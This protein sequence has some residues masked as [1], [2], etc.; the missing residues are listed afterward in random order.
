MSPNA[1][2]D[3]W[4]AWPWLLGRV[5]PHVLA[6]IAEAEGRSLRN[7]RRR[8]ARLGAR[9]RRG[10]VPSPAVKPDCAEDSR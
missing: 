1:R 7:V 6:E 9:G 3:A 8:Y 4:V 5:P 10:A 2:P